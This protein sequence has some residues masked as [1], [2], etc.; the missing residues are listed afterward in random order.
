MQYSATIRVIRVMCTGTISP[1]YVLKALQ[2]GADG[3][4]VAG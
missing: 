2:S 4:F 3:V 1:H